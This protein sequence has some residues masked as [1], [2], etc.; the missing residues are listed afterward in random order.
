M[1]DSRGCR[2][3]LATVFFSCYIFATGILQKTIHDWYIGH[4]NRSFESL[5]FRDKQCVS[6]FCKTCTRF[7]YKGAW[8]LTFEHLFLA[9]VRAKKRDRVHRGQET[10]EILWWECSEKQIWI[11]F[12]YC[13]LIQR[14]WHYLQGIISW[15]YLTFLIPKGM[16]IT[17]KTYDKRRKYLFCYIKSSI[18]ILISYNCKWSGVLFP[19]VSF[20]LRVLGFHTRYA[21]IPHREYDGLPWT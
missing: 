10:S 5:S 20:Y 1:R 21:C 8:V 11:I 9:T 12:Q 2:D 16:R 6:M 18:I 17:T 19:Q 14:L 7:W 13:L 4:Y 3:G 15:G